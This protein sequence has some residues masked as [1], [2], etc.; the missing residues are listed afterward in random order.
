MGYLANWPCTNCRHLAEEHDFD[1]VAQKYTACL[2]KSDLTTDVGDYVKH[3][4]NYVDYCD[5]FEPISNLEYL[6]MKN[7]SVIS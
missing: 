2:V 3:E 7:A 1:Q 4:V 6:E 5:G